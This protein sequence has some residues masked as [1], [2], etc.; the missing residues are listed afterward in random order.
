MV[1]AATACLTYWGCPFRLGIVH[2]QS[3]YPTLQNGDVL[4]LD[5]NYYRQHPVRAGDI[6]VLRHGG[7]YLTKRV[8]AAAGDRVTL[9]RFLEDGTYE[10]PTPTELTK[11]REACR[12]HRG[13]DGRIVTLQ[14]PPGECFVVGDN[15]AN[16]Y[17]SRQFG[18]VPTQ[19]VIGRM[20][21]SMGGA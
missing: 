2:G 3:M 15:R 8:F 4:L 1:L 14:V 6:V 21:V 19:D 12:H 11:L 10:I 18:F 9:L 17:D 13:Y 20:V 16:S 7:E 5:Q